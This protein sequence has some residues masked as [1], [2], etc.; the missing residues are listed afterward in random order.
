MVEKVDMG[1]SSPVAGGR[2]I[3]AL[4]VAGLTGPAGGGATATA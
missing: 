1:S 2:T 3:V 4:S